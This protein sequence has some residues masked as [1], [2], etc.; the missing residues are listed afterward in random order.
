MDVH[1]ES[2][3]QTAAGNHCH[4]HGRK[5]VLSGEGVVELSIPWDRQGPFDSQWPGKH[6]RRFPGFD[7]TI[8]AL[9][10]IR[11]CICHRP[12]LLGPPAPGG[13]RSIH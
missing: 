8:I 3:A 6:R 12:T 13:P 7:E 10:A 4:G 2:P 1:L 9:Y 5:A 11:P